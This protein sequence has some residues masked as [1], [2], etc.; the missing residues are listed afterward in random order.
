MQVTKP[1]SLRNEIR[2]A[3]LPLERQEFHDEAGSAFRRG[4]AARLRLPQHK[5]QGRFNDQYPGWEPGKIC[6]AVDLK[7]DIEIVQ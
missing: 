1:F 7:A 3:P 4:I 2:M 5:R 6:L